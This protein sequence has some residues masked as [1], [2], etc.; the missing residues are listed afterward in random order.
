MRHLRIVLPLLALAAPPHSEA[1]KDRNWQ[2][3]QDAT[4]RFWPDLSRSQHRRERMSP[5]DPKATF[6]SAGYQ[7]SISCSL[8]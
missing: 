3:A 7:P 5:I 8:L 2:A 1:V 6:V 4:D